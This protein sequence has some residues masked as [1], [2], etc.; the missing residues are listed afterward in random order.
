MRPL[1]LAALLA[2][3]TACVPTTVVPDG[4]RAR[5]H[6]ALDG[7]ARYLRVTASLH[8]FYGDRKKCLLLD[9]PPAEVDLIRGA[10]DESI[11]P[12]PAER[13]LPPGTPVRIQEVEFPTDTWAYG[14]LGD[15]FN[16]ALIARRVVMTPRYHPW[17]LVAL[18]G[19][20]RPCVVVL[21]QTVATAETALAE[22]GRLLTTD[23]PTPVL[24]ALPREQKEAVVRQELV[25][26]MPLQ[27]VEMA[28]G[29][30][31]HRHIDRPEGTEAWNWPGGKR[32]AY[33]RDE[34]LV[35]WER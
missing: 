32:R 23:D 1:L 33:F 19:E 28:W 10:R 4:E 9:A 5:T 20:A 15:L 30:P 2:L 11:P 18:A 34:K 31:E 13:L 26:G 22:T 29:V 7:Q 16:G 6:G 17:V 12:P 35:R 27:A 25:E 21:S 14:W 8:P 24:A 3:T